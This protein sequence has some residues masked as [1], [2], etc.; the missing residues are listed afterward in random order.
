MPRVALK[1]YFKSTI[2]NAKLLRFFSRCCTNQYS[3]MKFEMMLKAIFIAVVAVFFQYEISLATEFPVQETTNISNASSESPQSDDSQLRQFVGI[4]RAY[5]QLRFNRPIYLTGSGDGSG[6]IF[7]VEQGGVVRWFSQNE[8]NPTSRVFL[9]ISKLVSRS[10]NEEGLI[11]FAFHPDF[12]NNGQLFCHYSSNSH[13]TGEKEVASNVISRFTVSENPNFVLP[14]SEEIL[15]TVP[16]PFPNHNGGAMAFG[17]DGFLYFSLGDGGYKDDPLGNGQNLKTMLGGINRIDIDSTDLPKSYRIPGDNPFLNVK[18]AAPELYASGLRNVWRF[19]FDRKTGEL[20]A[21]DV[22]QA[23]TEEVNIIQKGGNYGWNRFEANE[24]FALDTAMAS[25]PHIAPVATYGHQ[26]GGSITGGNVYRGTRFPELDG[27]YFFGD[28]M[29]GNLWKT[30]KDTDG[31]YVTQ[32]VRRTGRSIASFGEDDKG[33]L[34]LLSFD[35]GIYR[36]VATSE[37]EN[38]FADWPQWLSETG[39]FASMKTKEPAADLIPYEVNAP[40]WSDNAQKSRF[41][42]L[43]KGSQLAYRESGSWEV[44]VG[45]TVVKNF[46]VKSRGNLRMFETRLIKRTANGWE[47][48]TYVWDKKGGDAELLTGGKQF[49]YWNSS[50]VHSWHAPSASECAS[51]HVDSAGYVLGLST[52]QLNRTGQSGKHQLTEWVSKGILS[53]PPGIQWDEQAKFCSPYD[54]QFSLEQRSRVWLD[55]NCAMCHRPA[56]SGN[57]TID[58]QFDTPLAETK[59]IGVVPA[60]GDLGIENAK[61]IAKGNPNQSLLVHRVETLGQGRMPGLGSNRIDTQAVEL[62]VQWIQQMAVDDKSQSRR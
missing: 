51:C 1:K 12:K 25:Q 31:R 41:F 29:T 22:G 32:L 17:K 53:A 21:A 48:A 27:A 8:E 2:L 58:L 30:T 39:L 7:V 57:A 11:G 44:P 56:G 16:Q 4:K 40:F 10:G 15:L 6:R 42:Q 28:Y 3:P 54:D 59:T 46:H 60:Q 19:S 35:G 24:D 23:R 37:P 20:W 26:W 61:I 38:T 36:I 13:R 47:A 18:G 14:D 62:L 45:A 52:R 55:V 43:P 49:E 5:S 9:D 33:E 50:V 34:Y